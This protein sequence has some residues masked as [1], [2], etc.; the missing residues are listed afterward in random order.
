MVALCGYFPGSRSILVLLAG[1]NSLIGMCCGSAPLASFSSVFSL[2]PV[3]PPY[4]KQYLVDMISLLGLVCLFISVFL[5]ERHHWS[6]YDVNG[7]LEC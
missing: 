7:S 2:F 4:L 5:L 3:F 1:S 6:D